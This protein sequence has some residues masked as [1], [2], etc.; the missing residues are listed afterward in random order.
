MCIR[1]RASANGKEAQR[2]AHR[3]LLIERFKALD[4]DADGEV[5]AD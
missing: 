2:K 5:D 4:A 3:R 1:D